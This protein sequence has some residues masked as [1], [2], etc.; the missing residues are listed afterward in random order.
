MGHPIVLP[1]TKIGNVFHIFLRKLSTLG[2]S[3][4]YAF[5]WKKYPVREGHIARPSGKSL[6]F[7]HDRRNI[8]RL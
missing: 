2:A 6:D 8:L 4:D 3:P 7:P 5:L 1:Q